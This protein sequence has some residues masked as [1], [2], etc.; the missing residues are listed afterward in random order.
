MPSLALD[1]TSDCSNPA[2]QFFVYRDG[3]LLDPV[4]IEY[5]IFDVSRPATMASPSQV[6]PE[7]P[8]NKATVDLAACP[9]GDKLGVGRYVAQF[10]P[11]SLGSAPPSGRYQLK[12]FVTKE[13]GDTEEV[14]TDEFDLLPNGTPV[15]DSYVTLPEFREEGVSLEVA[16]DERALLAIK[17]ARRYVDRTTRRQFEPNYKDIRVSGSG[18]PFV[19]LQEPIIALEEI[20]LDVPD[21]ASTEITSTA[22]FVFNR[23]IEAGLMS[24]DDRNNPK[25]EIRTDTFETYRNTFP[26]GV[27]NVRIK[28]VFGYTEPNGGAAGRTPDEI[29]LVTKKLALRELPTVLSAEEREAYNKRSRISLEKTKEQTVAYAMPRGRAQSTMYG[30]FTGD[31]DIDTILAAFVGPPML[32]AA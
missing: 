20:A 24:P 2:L 18:G 26:T 14:Y 29:V 1:A 25:V 15:A 21:I 5:Q 16:S 4:S 10:D 19:L 23:H 31:P 17:L 7:T 27:A 13:T 8:G 32:G 12:W 28:G 22:V 11:S 9:T 6:F 3:W 30:Y